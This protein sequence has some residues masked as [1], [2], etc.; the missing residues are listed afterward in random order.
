[1]RTIIIDGVEKKFQIVSKIN[2]KNTFIVENGIIHLIESQEGNIFKYM[3]DGENYKVKLPQAIEFVER[4]ESIM[5]GQ[6]KCFN[7]IAYRKPLKDEYYL[8]GEVLKA[9]RALDDM[10][11]KYIIQEL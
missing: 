6:R 8:S 4:L 9:Y 3:K 2:N 5:G 11:T 1:M 7:A 10:D